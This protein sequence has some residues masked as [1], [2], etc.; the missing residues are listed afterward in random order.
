MLEDTRN[1]AAMPAE[2]QH[3]GSDEPLPFIARA[4]IAYAI[5]V[6]VGLGLLAA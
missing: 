2:V 1:H 5:A 3:D 4:A 6:I